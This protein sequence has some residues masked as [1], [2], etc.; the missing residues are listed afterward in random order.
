MANGTLAAFEPTGTVT[1]AAGTTSAS[2][3]LAGGG[4]TVVV[5]NTSAALAFVRFD[6]GT[7]GV[8]TPS[9]MPVLPGARVILGVNSLIVYAAATLV[10]G[11]GN[12]LFTR[13]R[14]AFV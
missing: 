1:L 4:D 8:A 13:G 10:G 6:A 11:S 14:G 9:D 7:G 12:I 5:T 3:A 2:I